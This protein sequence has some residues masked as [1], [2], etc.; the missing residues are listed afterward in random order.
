M[1]LVI[2][3]IILLGYLTY[4]YII[5]INKQRIL[6]LNES[7][8][9]QIQ[10]ETISH[11]KTA[12]V[13][14]DL[15][16]NALDLKLPI[17]EIKQK[18]NSTTKIWFENYP[19][20]QLQILSAAGSE[21]MTF[22][23]PNL[24]IKLELPEFSIIQKTALNLVEKPN[25]Y[26][27]IN[28]KISTQSIKFNNSYLVL[29]IPNNFLNKYT[30]QKNQINCFIITDNK[31][32]IL[33]RSNSSKAITAKIKQLPNFNTLQQNLIRAPITLEK[34][35]IYL[36]G[37]PLTENFYL[38]TLLPSQKFL[39]IGDSISNLY[40]IASLIS[41]IVALIFL[42]YALK[43]LVVNPIK[44]LTE[45]SGK[46]N[47]ACLDI[48]LPSNKTDEFGSLYSCFNQMVIGLKVALREVEN[49]NTE[50]EQKVRLRTHRLQ[51]LN[52]ELET[53]RQKAEAASR[54]KS[55]FVANIS[56]ELRTPMNGILG[57]AQLVLKTPLNNKQRK[58][59]NIL[60]E[61]G[62]ALLNIINELLDLSKIEA[63]KMK[64]DSVPF[65]VLKTVKD[66]IT[67]LSIRA[68]EKGL[69]LKKQFD[70][71]IPKQVLGDSNRVRQIVLNLVG[72]AI[73]FTNEG[74]ITI[75]MR[76]ENIVN[77][78][79]QLRVA[80]ID[81]GI[82]IPQREVPYLFD[83][84]RQVDASTSRKYGGTGLGLFICRQLITL[85]G[86]QIGIYTQE[87]KGSTFWFTLSLP[88][89]KPISTTYNKSICYNKIIASQTTEQYK[90]DMP[91]IL[92]VEDDKLNQMVT[93][94]ALED[95]SCQLDIANHGEEA[96]IML[97]DNS[98]D[99]IFMD[100]H[101]P[102][103][104]GY[105]TT[106]QIRIN[107]QTT[108]NHIPII[109]MT[110]DNSPEDLAKCLEIGIDDIL[111]K[112]INKNTF[113]QMLEK[114]FH[115]ELVNKIK[116]GKI[117]LAEDNEANQTVQKMML[118]DMGYQ[119][120]IAIDGQQAIEM[121]NN[122]DYNLVLMDI[123]MPILNGCAT[124]ELIREQE[125]NMKTSHLPIIA[126]TASVTNNDIEKCM[127]AGMDGFL[128]KPIVQ[129]KLVEI[130]DKFLKN[131]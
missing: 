109:A 53:A 75:N 118:L 4:I 85:M 115:C 38:F 130:L 13:N 51:R 83:K 50:L 126:I 48:K 91:N 105:A 6:T 84:F 11:L 104:D 131:I 60:Y 62:N 90:T 87:E 77:N 30:T 54:T 44:I 26:F 129:T 121:I 95:S 73:K 61:S 34:I 107:E 55:Q 98:Y 114:W 57:M 70:D 49:A 111:H 64:L 8:L 93:E 25:P 39:A 86:G 68:E 96:L 80:V 23:N 5:D 65:D 27:L 106:K 117:L 43:Y 69:V 12:E 45:A 99:L 119:V 74:S 29:K 128:S 88:I 116:L 127:Q 31:G 101:M 110:A 47:V 24:A 10:Q 9:Q 15:L 81:T 16:I 66:T 28:K 7:L 102:I 59:I 124:T 120:D 32:Y 46:I 3:P 125:K 92:L 18:I 41:I 112:P 42:F 40:L 17:I 122:N 36:Q 14:L 58:Q 56:H 72:N 67:L 63:G 21:I 37:V 22:N 1:P 100:L 123:H 78:H 52:N 82:G 19:Y 35:S 97:T 79:L 71:K 2:I 20:S 89:V 108:K 76:L 33:F 94:M 113:N 103:L